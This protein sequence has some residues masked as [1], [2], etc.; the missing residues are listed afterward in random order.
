MHT[1][2]PGVISLCCDV[3]ASSDDMKVCLPT[4]N[5]V[6]RWVVGC[7]ELASTASGLRGLS[8]VDFIDTDGVE[9]GISLDVLRLE[10]SVSKEGP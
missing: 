6:S 9:S 4:A 3:L 8:A 2:I 5:T 1:S 10:M 7:F